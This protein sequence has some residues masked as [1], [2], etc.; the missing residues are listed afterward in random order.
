MQVGDLVKRKG[1]GAYQKMYDVTPHLGIVMDNMNGHQLVDVYWFR[2]NKNIL[3]NR[4]V[5]EV[6]SK[7]TE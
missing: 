2:D 4:H 3:T 5:V 6:V 1:W 7:C